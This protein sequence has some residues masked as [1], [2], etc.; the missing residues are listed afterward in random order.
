MRCSRLS[1][2]LSK[3]GHKCLF[4]LDKPDDLMNI[5]FKK[6][7]IYD[8]N[9]KYLNEVEDVKKFCK[10]TKD[11]GPGIVL[12][13]DYRFSK[14]WERHASKIHKKII[15]FDDLENKDHYADF[16]INYNP[17]NYPVIK[18]NFNR[19]KKKNCKFLIHPQFNIIEKNIFLND[20]KKD[21]L[22]K[23]TIYIGGG[24]DQ[25]IVY[26]LLLKLLKNLDNKKIKFVVIVGPLAK[27]K[28]KI[29][30]L[31]KKHNSIEYVDSPSSISKYIQ[32]SQ[33]FIGSAGT[34]IFETAFFK[35]PSILIKMTQNQETDIFSLEK[36][37]HYIYL[38][39]SDF[40]NTKKISKLIF[41]LEKNYSRFK[42][43]NIKPEIKIDDKGSKRIIDYI[44]SSK[45][46]F[47]K[48]KYQVL[49]NKIIKDK[50]SI[51]A[52]NDKDLNHY[53][54]SRNLE[55]NTNNSINKK[56]IKKLEHY[57]WWFET[58]RKSYVLTRNGLKVLYIYEDGIFS[59]KN[60]NYKISGWFACSKNCTIR[61]IL[62]A[63]N[64]Q[65]YK[66]KKHVKWLSFI[67]NSNQLSIKMSKY[68]G[69]NVVKSK[70]KSIDKLKSLLN[71]KSNKFIFY[72]R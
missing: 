22:F 59:S 64:W 70:D 3:K 11:M 2:E 1:L 18:Y 17:K 28:L 65:R 55:I 50:L 71:I 29:I 34:A 62:Y 27:N 13:D 8:D 43:L 58:S 25:I 36:L 15:I 19:N 42:V 72:K 47:P 68:L 21:N 67:K 54:A 31:A 52:V 33:L 23:I 46:I 69:W 57:L 56:K 20:K 44:F 63:L 61:E 30:Q 35:I 66:Y 14:K 32:G 4:F 37:G 16:I 6:F 7:Y 60:I 10:I 53:L 39:L 41:L 12:L 40:V 26:K 48:K 9:K 38:D 51:R 49:K 24:S 45:N 5:K